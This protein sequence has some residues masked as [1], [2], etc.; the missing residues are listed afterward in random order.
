MTI[1]SIG[2]TVLSGLVGGGDSISHLGGSVVSE[3]EGENMSQLLGDDDRL[4]VDGERD[5]DASVRALRP[6]SSRRGSWESE[7]SGWSARVLGAGA[8]ISTGSK[9]LWTSNSLKTGEPI[10][11]ED[12]EDQKNGEVDELGSI[13]AREP[14]KRQDRVSVNIPETVGGGK[15]REASTDISLTLEKAAGPSLVEASAEPP[16]ICA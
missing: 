7:I 14:S 9:S 4:E 15:E 5:A 11:G 13:L 16:A 2:S 10:G 12:E 6:R 1:G 3:P 8:G